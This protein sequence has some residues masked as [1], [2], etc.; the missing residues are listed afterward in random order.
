MLVWYSTRWK[1]GRVSEFVVIALSSVFANALV[2]GA[3]FISTASVSSVL[4]QSA[5]VPPWAASSMCSDP[6]CIP[7]TAFPNPNHPVDK[8]NYANSPALQ[9]F[10]DKLP[11]IPQAVPDTSSFP[12]SD[13]YAISVEDFQQKFHSSLGLAWLRGYRQT[14]G[15]PDLTSIHAANAGYGGPMIVATRDRPVRVRLTNNTTPGGFQLPVDETIMGAGFG[16]P[17]HIDANGKPIENDDGSYAYCTVAEAMNAA[18]QNPQTDCLSGNFSQER[19]LLHL[20]GGTNPWISDGTP[21]TWVATA[22]DPTMYKHGASQRNVPDMVQG[23]GVGNYYGGIG[24]NEA[25]YYYPNQESARL[26]F[27]HDHSYGLTRLNIYAGEFAPYLLIDD[28][29]KKQLDPGTLAKCQR[30]SP[31]C[32]GYT[33]PGILASVGLGNPQTGKPELDT[34]YGTVLVIQDKTFVKAANGSDGTTDVDPTWGTM[35]CGTDANN[36]RRSCPTAEGNLYFPHV[37]LPNQAAQ[38]GLNAMGRWDFAPWMGPPAFIFNSVLPNVSAV[39]ESFMDTM[40]VNGSAFPNMTVPRKPMRFRILNASN[41]RYLNLQ[42]YYAVNGTGYF[43]D[44]GTTKGTPC[45]T[46]GATVGGATEWAKCTEVSMVRAIGTANNG[47]PY[48]V[49]AFGNLTQA[50]DVYVPFDNRWGGVPDPRFQIPFVQ[51]GN[52]A[53]LLPK[54]IIHTNQAVDYEYDRKQINGLNVRNNP[55]DGPP[56]CAECVYPRPGYTLFLGPAE[57]ADIIVD[58]GTV[59]D[60]ATLILYNDAP[61]ATPTIDPRY[62]LYTGSPDFTST[63]GAGSPAKGYGPNNRTIMQFRV[64]GTITFKIP[65]QTSL[66]QAVLR[67]M[68]RFQLPAGF[69]TGAYY[70]DSPDDSGLL[71]QALAQD[72]PAAHPDRATGQEPLIPETVDANGATLPSYVKLPA[73]APKI[74]DMSKSTNPDIQASCDDSSRDGCA[75]TRLCGYGTNCQTG[76]K[77]FPTCAGASPVYRLDSQGQQIIDPST[78]QPI[79]DTYDNSQAQGYRRTCGFPVRIKSIAEDFEPIFGRMNA[80]LGT[81]ATGLEPAT[82]QTTFGHYYVDPITER[83]RDGETE[84]WVVVHN[85]VDTHAVHFHARDV[86]VINR[87][88]WA[89]SI[90]LPDPDERGLKDTVKMNPLENTIVAIRLSKPNLSAPYPSASWKDPAVNPRW[91]WYTD[92]IPPSWR[93]SDVTT[94]LDVAN[95]NDTFLF[96]FLYAIDPITNQPVS[97]KYE[98]FA[99]EYLWHC[100]LL[101]HEEND[102]MRPFVL[103]VDQ[104]AGPPQQQAAIP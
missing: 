12:G 54:P 64:D 49:P 31:T 39:P 92:G 82:G 50:M 1:S 73:D 96:P 22:N 65:G 16:P 27:Y 11:I 56:G 17:L 44:T 42:L 2:L 104:P 95:P 102:M 51:I 75:T 59:P 24:P 38:G 30:G 81:E 83:V 66:N 90:K 89:G 4:A 7:V 19:A 84:V 32:S 33:A 8:S 47:S 86:Q 63:G 13:Y 93:P 52:E 76:L 97:N 77:E 79:I 57:R 94:A 69:V 61:G 80:M 6:A 72:Y 36:G 74:V 41:D 78:G 67:T 37:Y 60:G 20:H 98:N 85:G 3:F 26:M 53:G 18:S 71:N 62:D 88:D 34:D 91:Y 101:G 21:H 5:Q 46:G 9:K 48:H 14:N 100:H 23:I 99:W 40:V 70:T 45:R 29:E 43:K 55:V 68:K 58:F 103:Q 25:T 10:V 15:G 87:V 28:I 35:A